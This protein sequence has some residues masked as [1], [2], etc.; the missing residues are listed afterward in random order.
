MT[1]LLN[2]RISTNTNP[3]PARKISS[4]KK[5]GYCITEPPQPLY[6]YSMYDA[7]KKEEERQLQLKKEAIKS[8]NRKQ[9]KDRTFLKILSVVTIATIFLTKKINKKLNLP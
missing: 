5:E 9:K 7:I 4:S 6:K 3:I 2:S 8:I 1:N